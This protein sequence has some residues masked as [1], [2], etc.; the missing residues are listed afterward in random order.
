MTPR[1][2]VSV[3]YAVAFAPDITLNLAVDVD[4]IVQ[5]FLLAGVFALVASELVI[6]PRALLPL[7]RALIALRR[8]SGY[9]PNEMTKVLTDP[10]HPTIGGGFGPG[11]C[12][13]LAR[14]LVVLLVFLGDPV[15]S[16]GFFAFCAFFFVPASPLWG[17]AG[18]VVASLPSSSSSI[19]SGSAGGGGLTSGAVAALNPLYMPCLLA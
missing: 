5:A 1:E 2:I 10:D 9:S 14:G 19:T 6:G 3:V 16:S 18:V 7:L 4:A 12:P 11:V 8:V 15:F 17:V 13:F